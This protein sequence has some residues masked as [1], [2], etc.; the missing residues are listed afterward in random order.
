MKTNVNNYITLI[1]LLQGKEITLEANFKQIFLFHCLKCND[2]N[3]T[4]KKMHNIRAM[5]L[6]A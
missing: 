1:Q 4:D 6:K 3:F 2:G 5:L